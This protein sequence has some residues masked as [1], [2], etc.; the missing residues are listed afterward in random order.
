M[1][2]ATLPVSHFGQVPPQRLDLGMKLASIYRQLD[3]LVLDFCELGAQLGILGS[4]DEQ[5]QGVRNGGLLWIEQAV[6]VADE[7]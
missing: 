4:Q 7:G 5:E 1:G 3:A 2:G 6:C